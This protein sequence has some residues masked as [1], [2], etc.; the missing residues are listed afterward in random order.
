MM[1]GFFSPAIN[2]RSMAEKTI[3]TVTLITDEFGNRV[4]ISPQEG[5]RLQIEKSPQ[6]VTIEDTDP[7]S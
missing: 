4:N 6:I 1:G 5:G 2:N 3:E 7:T